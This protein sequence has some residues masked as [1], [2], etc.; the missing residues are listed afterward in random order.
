M[1]A[2]L[3]ALNKTYTKYGNVSQLRNSHA[4]MEFFYSYI[5]DM[6]SISSST[7]MLDRGLRAATY[8]L[9]TLNSSGQP[10]TWA[11]IMS[12][13]DRGV[14]YICVFKIRPINFRIVTLRII[15]TSLRH[16]GLCE[17]VFVQSRCQCT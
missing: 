9:I 11:T 5:P 10:N 16:F 8:Q 13:V 3:L 4:I 17:T 7:Y 12:V 1:L 14:C 6:P 2:Y 15:K